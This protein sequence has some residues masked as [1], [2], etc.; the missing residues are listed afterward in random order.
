MHRRAYAQ[1]R[2]HAFHMADETRRLLYHGLGL[3]LGLAPGPGPGLGF[4]LACSFSSLRG[5][6]STDGRV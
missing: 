3:G 6:S 2:F 1:W 4:G 5:A